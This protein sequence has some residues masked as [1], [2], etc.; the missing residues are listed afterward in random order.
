MPLCQLRC[1]GMAK[2]P[3]SLL[4]PMA[5]AGHYVEHRSQLDWLHC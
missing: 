2:T 3:L 4:A 5:T 1:A